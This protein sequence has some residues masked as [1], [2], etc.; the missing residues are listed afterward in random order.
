[1]EA[2]GGYWRRIYTVKVAVH[3]LREAGAQTRLPD[4]AASMGGGQARADGRGGQRAFPVQDRAARRRRGRR[5]AEGD[6]HE[7]ADA[8][9]EGVAHAEGDAEAC[10]VGL[11]ASARLLL[12]QRM[13]VLSSPPRR[14]GAGRMAVLAVLCWPSCPALSSALLGPAQYPQAVRRRH[15]TL[16][17]AWRALHTLH[18]RTGGP[19]GRAAGAVA[20]QC[21]VES[22]Q[23]CS[24]SPVHLH[25]QHRPPPLHAR[26]LP[27]SRPHRPGTC[28]LRLLPPRPQ[29]APPSRSPP[30]PRRLRPARHSRDDCAPPPIHPPPLPS[31]P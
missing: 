24:I 6:A 26:S 9:A 20:V 10:A 7:E 19:R 14:F 28:L 8:H 12:L 23:N 21:I 16:P 4:R 30:T 1:M 17:I 31:T 5:I 29:I 18:C 15:C 2:V 22:P 25:P 11:A 27:S 13:A 3:R